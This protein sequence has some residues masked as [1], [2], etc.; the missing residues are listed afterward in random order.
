VEHEVLERERGRL[1]ALYQQL[2]QQPQ[3]QQHKPSYS[4]RR[5]TSRDL[6]QQ[7]ANLTLK[8]KEAERDAVSGQLHI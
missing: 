5:S 6:D 7:F 8:Q 2:H 4:H 3:P 1:R